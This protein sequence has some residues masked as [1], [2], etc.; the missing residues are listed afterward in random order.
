MDD[1]K[2]WKQ[3]VD[4][5]YNTNKPNI[6]YSH[7]EGSSQFFKGVMWAKAAKAGYKWKIGDE[8]MSNFGKQL[9]GDL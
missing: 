2:M 6:F 1:D 5:K 3:I 4:E 9:A 7:I 8:K